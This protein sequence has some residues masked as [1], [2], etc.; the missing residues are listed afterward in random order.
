[1]FKCQTLTI[2]YLKLRKVPKLTHCTGIN[3]AFIEHDF[4]NLKVE[5]LPFTI[6]S[7]GSL[8]LQTQNPSTQSPRVRISLTPISLILLISHH[9]SSPFYYPPSLSLSSSPPPSLPFPSHIANTLPAL[10]NFAFLSIPTN[11]V[12]SLISSISSTGFSMLGK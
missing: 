11:P 5:M 10:V 3:V 7:A 8:N 4:Q 2:G 12:N 1:M 9:I 6:K